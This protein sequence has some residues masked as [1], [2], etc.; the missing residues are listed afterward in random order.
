ME[1]VCSI[2]PIIHMDKSSSRSARAENFTNK[3]RAESHS[4]AIPRHQIVE[5]KSSTVQKQVWNPASQYQ[6]L[7]SGTISIIFNKFE[8]DTLMLCR[9]NSRNLP[10]FCCFSF[11]KRDVIFCNIFLS[12]TTMKPSRTICSLSYV[13]NGFSQNKRMTRNSKPAAIVSILKAHTFSQTHWRRE[14][15]KVSKSSQLGW[16]S[17]VLR[18][19]TTSSSASSPSSPPSP[20]SST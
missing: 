8:S 9:N 20:S 12:K 11:F 16:L 6:P 2:W 18:S 17:R 5:V 14:E 19:N 10:H 4:A 1:W 3:E 7:L 15:I 13:V